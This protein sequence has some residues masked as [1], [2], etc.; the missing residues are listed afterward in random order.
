[1]LTFETPQGALIMKPEHLAI[2]GWAGRDQAGVQHHIEELAELGVKPPSSVP[3]FYRASGQLLT[4][5]ENVEMLG[6]EGSGEAEVCLVSDSEGRL[7]V[8]LA[9]DH[10]DRKLE[11]VGVAESK[12]LCAKPVASQAW[13]LEEIRD[14]WDSLELSSEIEENGHTVTYQQG[15]LAE[16]LDVDTLL[17]K[18]PAAL[19]R[20]ASLVPNTLLL[21][22]TVP[23][24]GGIRPS[25]RFSMTLNDPVLNRRLSHVYSVIELEVAQ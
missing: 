24:I 2:A 19:K 25:P 4:Q 10:T 11:A 8:T 17:A 6:G 20:G 23:A 5:D 15:T 3:L 13:A 14:H 1:M 22:G 7:W 16:L 21:C 18:L 9:S 12:Q